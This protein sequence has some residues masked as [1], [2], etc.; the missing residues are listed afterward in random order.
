[1]RHCTVSSL[2]YINSCKRH[3]TL[4]SLLYI[5]NCERHWT[6]L[7]KEVYCEHR[8]NLVQGLQCHNCIIMLLMPANKICDYRTEANFQLMYWVICAISQQCVYHHLLCV[9]CLCH[10]VY[11]ALSGIFYHG[12]TNRKW[13]HHLLIFY[14]IWDLDTLDF[15][16]QLETPGGSVYSIAISSHHILCGTYENCIHVSASWVH[17]LPECSLY[18]C[19]C[20]CLYLWW[21]HLVLNCAGAYRILS[22]FWRFD[23][24]VFTG[25][26]N[27]KRWISE[28]CIRCQW[29][30]VKEV[31]T[32]SDYLVWSNS[33]VLTLTVVW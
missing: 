3:C 16:R 11:T 30:A 26:S 32:D 6:G 23:L 25:A 4:S 20:Y 33:R 10:C 22:I 27:V 7:R 13:M 21:L 24:V 5:D 8:I 2:M 1:M 9:L 12:F 15:I 28:R 17:V 31:P 29:S 19:E 14:Q 18:T